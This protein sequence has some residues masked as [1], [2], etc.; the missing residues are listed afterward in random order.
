MSHNPVK[1]PESRVFLTDGGARID[2]APTYMSCMR[3]G[4]VSQDFG[5]I[6]K[7]ECPSPTRYNAFDEIGEIQGAIGRATMTLTGRFI[8]ELRST[9]LRIA[10]KRCTADIDIHFGTCTAPSNF[11]Q[12]K[13]V[14]KLLDAR[15]T[16]YNTDDLG[17]LAS[18]ESNPINESADFSAKEIVQLLQM[19][20]ASRGGSVITNQL[21]DVIVCDTPSCGDCVDESDGCQ[22]F[23]AISLAAGGSSGTPPDLVYS[24][25]GGDNIY[26]HDIDSL[27]AA[28]N[29]D[30]IGCLADYLVVVSNDSGSLHYVL[31]SSVT[32]T[33][34]HTWA[35]V[36]TGF[37]G[38]GEPND[39]WSTGTYAFIVGDG[40]YVYGTADPTGGVTVLDAG[41]ATSNVLN[42]VH[43]LTDDFAVAVGNSGTVIKTEN[44]TIWSALTPFVG[45]GVHLY[46][47]WLKSEQEWL[48]GASNGNLYYTVDGGTTW[49][50]K[51]FSGSGSGAVYDISFSND[52]VGYLAHATT[53][54]LGRI[55]RTIDGGYSWMV[56]PDSG[57]MP[58][59]DQITALA[60][61]TENANF[62]VGVGL[63]DDAADGVMIVGEAVE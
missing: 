18:D 22:K 38:G 32:T 47:V 24:L 50:T 52:A 53:A 46:C 61:C 60:A 56:E 3:A 40:G 55:L 8:M 33:G 45:V 12:W 15:A 16:T 36:T 54:P 20:Y 7:I 25:D 42:A 29:A 1:T 43:A 4:G 11:N 9:L 59:Q 34:D 5:D 57:T 26:A 39:I 63:A 35:E 6:T 28:E 19:T 48:I 21:M 27:G 62:V 41:V 31:K 37:V 44:G 17:A 23:Y 10:Q 49:T 30:A 51:A 58:A 13:M 2:H 14:L